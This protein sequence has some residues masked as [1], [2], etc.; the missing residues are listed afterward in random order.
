[1]ARIFFLT[2]VSDPISDEKAQ[3]EIS[4]AASYQA[5]WISPEQAIV[6]ARLILAA[7]GLATHNGAVLPRREEEIDARRKTE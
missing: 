5:Y 3:R 2:A 6:C 1:M 4:L 7:W